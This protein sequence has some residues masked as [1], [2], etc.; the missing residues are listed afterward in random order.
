MD[1]VKE[2][3]SEHGGESVVEG[4]LEE[5]CDASACPGAED[6]G[7]FKFHAKQP[8]QKVMQLSDSGVSFRTLQ[9]R[10]PDLESVFLTLTGRSLRDD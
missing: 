1:S 4:E 6:N 8:L 10:E 3:L 5:G 2:L 9:I 7:R